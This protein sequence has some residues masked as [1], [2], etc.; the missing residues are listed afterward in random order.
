M[1]RVLFYTSSG[2]PRIPVFSVLNNI[3]VIAEQRSAGAG[4]YCDQDIPLKMSPHYVEI[5][6]SPR[7]FLTNGKSN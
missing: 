5:Q 3:I 7:Q 2:N 1:D 4:P 6:K